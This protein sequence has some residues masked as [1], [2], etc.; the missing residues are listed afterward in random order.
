MAKIGGGCGVSSSIGQIG[1]TDGSATARK[2]VIRNKFVIGS[3]R[4]NFP[5]FLPVSFTGLSRFDVHL[6]KSEL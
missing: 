6:P 4:Q 3:K 1:W 2:V 5:V